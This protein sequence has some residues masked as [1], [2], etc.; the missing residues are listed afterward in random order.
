[1]VTLPKE[2]RLAILIDAENMS[3]AWVGP[4]LGRLQSPKVL[5]LK[6]A[7][8]DWSKA[9]LN[10]WKP[11]LSE[12]GIHPVHAP[13][14]VAGKNSADMMLT[15]D[16]ITLLHQQ[17]TWFCIVSND[18]DF[19]PLVHHLTGAGA[20]VV[21][22][23]SHQVSQAFAKACHKFVYL[24]PLAKLQPAALQ[25]GGGA[26]D[27]AVV[28]P[29]E[30]ILSRAE[31]L[32]WLKKVYISFAVPDTWI[33]LGRFGS[34]LRKQ[35]PGFDHKLFGYSALGKL[36]AIEGGHLFELR[37]RPIDPTHPQ[38]LILQ[39]RLRQ[40]VAFSSSTHPPNS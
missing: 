4:V 36:I 22:F 9:Q 7:Y 17:I 10:G 3:A 6:R 33:D 32:Q 13:T 15:I 25:G 16:A 40:S 20:K 37:R 27:G 21:G 14:Y 19:T 28:E 35:Y 34:E 18:S 2:T 29:I 30:P 12:Y 8:G 11:V 38:H 24:K 1:M 39:I 5:T 26:G 31:L 23:G